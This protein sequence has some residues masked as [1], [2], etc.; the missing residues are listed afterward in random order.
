MVLRVIGDHAKPIDILDTKAYHFTGQSI[1]ILG[2]MKHE[3]IGRLRCKQEG[4]THERPQSTKTVRPVASAGM[5]FSS[6][7]VKKSC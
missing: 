5:N 6:R 2:R 7:R 3:S 4:V 1:E